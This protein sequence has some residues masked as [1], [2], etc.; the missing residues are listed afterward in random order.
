MLYSSVFVAILAEIVVFASIALIF[1]VADRV[2]PANVTGV[3]ME[4]KL[5]FAFSLQGY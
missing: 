4:Q 3:V 1:L 5:P 2:D